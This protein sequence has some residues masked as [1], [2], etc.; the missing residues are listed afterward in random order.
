MRSSVSHLVD[1][2]K[3]KGGALAARVTPMHRMRVRSTNITASDRFASSTL[4]HL[5][6]VLSVVLVLIAGALLS[7]AALPSSTP[8][9]ST[10]PAWHSTSLPVDQGLYGTGRGYRTIQT[11]ACPSSTTCLAGGG[12]AKGAVLLTTSNAGATWHSTSLPVDHGLRSTK[13]ST[14]IRVITC[15]S[16]T[17]CLA[18]GYDTK[19]ALLLGGP[20]PAG[21]T[22][23]SKLIYFGGVVVILLIAGVMTVIL[24]RRRVRRDAVAARTS[25]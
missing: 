17:T 7:Q 13:D 1:N 16:S 4:R 10:T 2:S 25:A 23:E 24:W 20:N 18:G 3:Q 11:I 22:L 19:G 21:N 6:P 15:P 14:G 8:V 9:S 5:L 12:S